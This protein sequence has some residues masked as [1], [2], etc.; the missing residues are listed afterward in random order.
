VDAF[1]RTGGAL[2]AYGSGALMSSRDGGASWRA[3]RVPSRYDLE[4]VDFVDARRG[5]ATD[6]NWRL[7]RTRDGGRSW[8]PALGTGGD[9]V[10]AISFADARHGFATTADER[11]GQVLRTSDGGRTW[12]PQAVESQDLDEILALGP[13]SAVALAAGTNRVYTTR[14]GGD[15]GVPSRLTIHARLR[16][17]RVA[18]GGRLRPAAGGEEVSVAA[19]GRRFWSVKQARVARNGRFTTTW[20]VR[21]GTVFVAQWAGAPGV[22]GDG[23]P[24]LRIRLGRHMRR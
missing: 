18:I 13:S 12:R 17:G 5:W 23:T 20:R 2:I 16:R 7:W 3:L 10:V 11:V 21:R 8:V 19:R 9:D 22:Q 6:E 15:A 1:D 24:P 4:S 14:T